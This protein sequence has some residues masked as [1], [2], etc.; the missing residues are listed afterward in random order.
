MNAHKILS[1]KT[2]SESEIK[3]LLITLGL[4]P[5]IVVSTRLMDDER[6]S[7]VRNI[8]RKQV[9]VINIYGYSW[10]H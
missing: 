2:D 4:T 10:K 9:N 7:V 3:R 6:T 5:S 8:V 1:W